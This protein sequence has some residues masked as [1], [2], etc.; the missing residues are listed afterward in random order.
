MVLMRLEEKNAGRAIRMFQTVNDRG[1]PLSLFDKL[2]ALLMLYSN[3]FCNEE[4]DDKI[5]DIFGDIFKISMQIK[6]HRAASSLADTQFKNEV[7]NRI[8]SI[9]FCYYFLPVFTYLLCFIF[10][11]FYFMPSKCK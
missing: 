5:N 1:V 6:E 2:K 3:K 10:V 11:V 8:F 4:L 7:E 9:T